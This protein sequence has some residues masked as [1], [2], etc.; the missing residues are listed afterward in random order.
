MRVD[1]ELTKKVASLARL[2]LT[3]KEVEEMTSSMQDVLEAFSTLQEVDT[4]GVEPS[5]IP[6]AV[7]DVSR[8]D[9][10]SEPVSQK[11]ILSLSKETKDGY[12][13]GPKAV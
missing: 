3:D 1:A 6:V 12:F 8:V 4:E 10:P 5:V 13:L 11:E 9:N 2:E 7:K